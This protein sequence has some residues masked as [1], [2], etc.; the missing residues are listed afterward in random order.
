MILMQKGAGLEC[1]FCMK[2]LMPIFLLEPYAGVRWTAAARLEWKWN[3]SI[4]AEDG[5][6]GLG[7]GAFCCLMCKVPCRATVRSRL[8]VLVPQFGW[9]CLPLH[10]D[11][12][13]LSAGPLWCAD[14]GM[15]GASVGVFV[16]KTGPVSCCCTVCSH[17]ICASAE[18]I[19]CA[20]LFNGAVPGLFGSVLAGVML[21]AGF[22]EQYLWP[23]IGTLDANWF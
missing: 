15:V 22:C 5:A 8:C 12:I 16:L 11:C 3:G 14:D 7:A 21:L 6:A 9:C 2:W 10:C 4:T 13:E 17:V 1:C 23:R 20:D 18:P 19:L